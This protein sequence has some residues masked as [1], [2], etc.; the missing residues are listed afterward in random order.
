MADVT[1]KQLA[2]TIGTPVDRL[3]QQ[4]QEAGLPQKTENDSVAEDQK[5][6]LLSYLK[7]SHGETETAPK[8]ITLKRRTL[9]TLK[10]G[11]SAGRGRTVNVEVRKKRTYVRRTPTEEEGTPAAPAALVEEPAEPEQETAES[12]AEREAAELDARRREAYA[13]VEAE[14]QK[15]RAETAQK[16]AEE[17][18]KA[19]REEAA[20]Q[21]AAGKGQPAVAAAEVTSI[22]SRKD[23]RDRHDLDDDDK[24]QKKSKH[25]NRRRRV[26]ELA[27]APD[28]IF[29]V[30]GIVK[31]GG[32][33]L[34]LA[35]GARPKRSAIKK[36]MSSQHKFQAPT[37]E[38]Q[39]EV[40]LG[41]TITVQQLSQRMS[42][43][44]TDVIKSL[45]GLGIMANINQT[46]DQETA[47]MVIEEFGHLVKIVDA[48]AAE[49]TMEDE[50]VYENEAKP[51]A[52]VVTVMGHV[53]HGKTSLLDYIRNSRVAS[54]EAGGITQHIGAYRVST[55]HGEICFID[56]PGHAAFTAM[57]ARGANATDIV[58]LVVAAD[59][60]VMPQ[61]EEAIQHAKTAGVP[62][63]VAINK[64]DKEGADP[65]RAKNEL[66]SREVIPDD[67]GG[68]TQF[69]PVSA[70][71]GQGVEDLLEAIN[72]QA[73][74]LELTAVEDG[75]A[76][77]VVIESEL[78]KGKGPVA[79]LLIQN[80]TLKQGDIIVAGEQ[81]GRVRALSDENGKRAKTAGPATP[82]S[83]LGLNGTPAAGESFMVTKDEKR[84]REVAELRRDR[85]TDE[86][87]ATPAVSL[88][89]LL[90][91]FSSTETSLLNLVVKADVRGSLEAIVSALN[92]LGND[93][94][95]VNVVFSGVGGITESDVTLAGTSGAVIFGFNVRA[96]NAAKKFVEKEGLDLRYYK[97][98]YDL[99]DDVR[100]ALTGMLSP[101]IREE[102][103]GIA[104]VRDV[105]DSKKLGSIAGCMVIEGTV[106]RSKK[107]RVLR[108][109]IVIYEG[110]L[111][112]LRRY[113]DEVEDVRSGVECGIGVKNY[114]DVKVGDQIEVFDTREVAREL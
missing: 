97:V 111:E 112:S 113:K 2:E 71:T 58:I 73:E 88:D 76:Q 93:E 78:D 56:T 57:R 79:T 65:E 50:L 60:G 86:R 1:V 5:E 74:L 110:E 3:L 109:N 107:I 49:K 4:M 13:E 85:A 66:A 41:E 90:E 101:E 75:P 83:V 104:E 105:F 68:D 36:P 32:S 40:E 67:W 35:S 80:G 99:V 55:D 18:E 70:I 19:A 6:K 25:G 98:I 64:I 54:G 7:K 12:K 10:T 45:M 14:A 94:V 15:R 106:S 52:P 8:K 29:D 21:K 108:D 11:G 23:K 100:D 95:K 62:L 92:D 27:G 63:I 37:E 31:K 44:A 114:N 48:N 91:S 102:I 39:H 69:I 34:G 24:Q 59:D 30:N 87:L 72:L 43:K 28:E 33:T 81:F 61:T 96:E 26:E 84:A 42:V 38:Q 77:G 103:V 47:M 51:R 9:S 89:N 17:A 53:D 46:V 20:K 16:E 82:V 22:S